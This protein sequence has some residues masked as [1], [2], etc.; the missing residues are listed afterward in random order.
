M[1]AH[2]PKADSASHRMHKAM[3]S[4]DKDMKATKMTGDT[5]HDFAMM[6]VM[7]HKTA[8]VMGE[9]EAKECKDPKIRA[10][11]GT[12]DRRQPAQGDRR[13]RGVDEGAPRRTPTRI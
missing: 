4:A 2:E 7:H 12:E 1:T 3:E 9:I 13:I 8:I 5:D 11:H 6:M 10:M